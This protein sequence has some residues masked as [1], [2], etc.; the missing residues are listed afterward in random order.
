MIQTIDLDLTLKLKIPAIPNYI[1]E[2]TSRSEGVYNHRS[3][4]I[5]D[6]TDSQ[7]RAIGAAWIENLLET[8]RQGHNAPQ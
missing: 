5:K 3:F 6:L 8:A 2:Y 7:L 1:F 4:S